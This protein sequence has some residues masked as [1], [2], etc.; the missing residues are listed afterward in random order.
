MESAPSSS[1]ERPR[2]PILELLPLDSRTIVRPS[3]ISIDHFN[4][5]EFR[6]RLF[7][8]AGERVRG[9]V[10]MSRHDS[11]IASARTIGCDRGDELGLAT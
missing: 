7:G 9:R 10:R 4:F 8:S 2:Q 3:M 6:I 11:G 1:S 5:G